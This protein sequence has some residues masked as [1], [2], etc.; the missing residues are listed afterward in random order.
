[1]TDTGNT[2][3]GSIE[4]GREFGVD[5]LGKSANKK[6]KPGNIETDVIEK[7]NFPVFLFS[8]KLKDFSRSARTRKKNIPSMK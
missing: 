6:S 8:E 3:D 5:D 1:M 4:S 7:K 2:G